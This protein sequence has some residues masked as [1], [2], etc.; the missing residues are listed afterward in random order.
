M[1]TEHLQ[2]VRTLPALGGWLVAIGAT[3]LLVF[4]FIAS[5]LLGEGHGEELWVSVA[6]IAGFWA[7]GYFA[8]FRAM[9]AP[10][11]H[12]IALGLTSILVWF[13]LNLLASLFFPTFRWEGLTPELTAGLLVA[14]IVASVVGALMGYNMALRGRPSLEEHPPEGVEPQREA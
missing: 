3:S 4:V 5:G 2:N 10:I 7:G 8:G 12:G 11:L 9:Q 6:L 1:H 13:L 14:H